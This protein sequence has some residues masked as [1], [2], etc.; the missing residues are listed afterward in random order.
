[1]MIRKKET[2]VTGIAS[3]VTLSV[4][5]EAVFVSVMVATFK[6]AI[7]LSNEMQRSH[8]V[9]S[10]S[11]N[12]GMALYDAYQVGMS[13][14]WDGV[15][16]K[17][18]VDSKVETLTRTQQELSSKAAGLGYDS[19]LNKLRSLTEEASLILKSDFPDSVRRDGGQ[20]FLSRPD[21]VRRICR[22][23]VLASQSNFEICKRERLRIKENQHRFDRQRQITFSFLGA[24]LLLNLSLAIFLVLAFNKRM[25]SRMQAL[26]QRIK[27]FGKGELMPSLER[28]NDEIA[29]IDAAF[30][31]MAKQVL[32]AR[33]RFR[34][35]LDNVQD[36]ICL[37]DVH[38][39]I[40]L[41][42]YAFQRLSGY[43]ESEILQKPL[44]IFVPNYPRLSALFYGK[45]PAR[46]ELPLRR[47]DLSLLDA[48]WAVSRDFQSEGHIVLIH[49]SFEEAQA[50][51]T[52]E[53]SWERFQALLDSL[54]AGLIVVNQEVKTEYINQTAL[55]FLGLQPVFSS[56]LQPELPSDL[57]AVVSE[58]I[59]RLSSEE[60][61]FNFVKEEDKSLDFSL[62]VVPVKLDGRERFVVLLRD[63]SAR[64]EIERLKSYFLN[65]ISHD[66]RTPL[67]SVS[68]S[69]SLVQAGANATLNQAQKCLVDRVLSEIESL[70][71]VVDNFLELEQ[72]NAGQVKP[73]K[74]I[75]SLTG[76]VAE[77]FFEVQKIRPGLSFNFNKLAKEAIVINSKTR[78]RQVVSYVI[79]YFLRSARDD[80]SLAAMF[81]VLGSRARFTL[82]SRKGIPLTSDEGALAT[83]LYSQ[84]EILPVDEVFQDLGLSVAARLAILC[85]ADFT[86]KVV[87]STCVE[88]QIDFQPL[89]LDAASEEAFI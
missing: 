40:V 85:S 30:S 73:T 16:A 19:Y 89:E 46:I 70:N 41:T 75:F 67:T 53:G 61:E 35:I 66:L 11:W 49:D 84:R 83:L 10:A 74:Q 54:L 71:T 14:E 64:K 23:L 13:E 3:I 36:A 81:E 27:R 87:G 52:V 45:L 58:Q 86:Y 47:S 24:G 39:R 34:L 2:L 88:F 77:I 33:M 43:G 50:K 8:S 32:T 69:M 21:M 72:L 22:H 60:V 82:S 38:E 25:L 20:A 65:M 76:L 80:D 6:S 15:S 68:S 62:L 17:Q 48:T 12:F 4:L 29:A 26:N 5:F 42:N 31:H 63:V 44:E 79:S 1:M 9:I 18:L 7:H 78:L 59:A 37:T 28:G 56:V 55:G 57:I 51:R